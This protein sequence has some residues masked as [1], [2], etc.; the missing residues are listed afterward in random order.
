MTV[1]QG[2]PEED[3]PYVVWTIMTLKAYTERSL[4]DHAAIAAERHR[5][6][7]D[8]MAMLLVERDRRYSERFKAQ[9]EARRMALDAVNREFHEHI[10]QVRSET[11]AALVSSE[12]AIGK[13]ETAN[14][15]RFESVNEFRQQ[16]ADQAALFIP[17]REAEA[18]VATLG[19]K[20]ATSVSRIE[21]TATRADLAAQVASAAAAIEGVEKSSLTRYEAAQA[22]MTGIAEDIVALKVFQS[23]VAGLEQLVQSQK[24]RLDKTEGKGQGGQALWGYLV[25]AIGLI[26]TI[27][28]LA[29]VLTSNG[30]P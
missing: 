6:H 20:V 14:E 17:R 25:G 30:G 11:Q 16:L 19:E 3:P 15:K 12:R 7:V 2:R 5:G 18:L 9:E 27:V 23:R 22:R 4:H 13:S 1:S 28:T 24:E 8:H 26:L 21:L 10:V 29:N